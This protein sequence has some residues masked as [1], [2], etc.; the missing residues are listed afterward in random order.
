M[1]SVFSLTAT[2]SFRESAVNEIV[3]KRE[4]VDREGAKS[5]N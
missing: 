5:A 1:I 3:S 4:S 2:I